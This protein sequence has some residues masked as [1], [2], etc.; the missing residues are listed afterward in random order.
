MDDV[1]ESGVFISWIN[2]HG[3][4]QGLGDALGYKVEFVG[5]HKNNAILR[6]VVSAARTI[7]ILRRSRP[8]VVAIMMP[9]LPL[10]IAIRIVALHVPV[11][12]LADLHSGVFLDPK[13]RWALPLTLKLLRKIDIALVTN[14]ELRQICESRDV[15]TKVVHDPLPP[16]ACRVGLNHDEPHD[17]LIVVPLSYANDEPIEEILAAAALTTN[18]NWT[19]T[20][21]APDEV[22][23]NAPANVSFTGYLENEQYEHLLHSASVI[24][25]LTNRPHTMQRAAY[26]ALAMATPLV[27]S[28]F[29]ELRAYFGEAASY[30]SI[31]AASIALAVTAA[32]EDRTVGIERLRV[33]FSEK[34]MEEAQTLVDLKS[35]IAAKVGVTGV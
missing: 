13:W 17:N 10:L 34:T 6:Y 30:T 2:Y 8:A 12:I 22:R 32:H 4:S 18:F 5:S 3:R 31:D 19:L 26:E 24:V 7:R 20:G 9:P 27:T 14:P 28:N 35:A 16:G 11:V 21:T 1:R 33:K 29:A 15:D 25:A 23:Q